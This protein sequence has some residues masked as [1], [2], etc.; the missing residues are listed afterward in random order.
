CFCYD[1]IT[2]DA[3]PHSGWFICFA[4]SERNGLKVTK[5]EKVKVSTL[6]FLDSQTYKK[7]A[8]AVFLL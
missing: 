2:F 6:T 4:P 7:T 8:T 5:Y 1:G 3:H